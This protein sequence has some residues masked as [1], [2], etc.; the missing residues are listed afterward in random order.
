MNNRIKEC[1][2][3]FGLTQQEPADSVQV[4]RETIIF[5]EQSKYNPSLMPAYHLSRAFDV[6]IEEFFS[7]D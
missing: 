3:R 4:C 2:T 5:L 1:R 6:T 7:F